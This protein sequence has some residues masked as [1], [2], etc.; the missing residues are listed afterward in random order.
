MAE[1]KPS[2]TVTEGG[3]GLVVHRLRKSYRRRPVIRDVSLELGPRR[4][5]RWRY[6][7]AQRLGQRKPPSFYCI[8]GG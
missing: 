6:S 4:T 2:L 3:Q 5:G 1:G 7:R 8:R